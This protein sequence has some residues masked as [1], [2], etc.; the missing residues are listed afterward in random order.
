VINIQ[1][2]NM[3]LFVF[4]VIRDIMNNYQKA[5]VKEILKSV[6][7]E[8]IKCGG[9]MKRIIDLYDETLIGYRCK[10][11]PHYNLLDDNPV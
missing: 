2:R 11:C 7:I 3:A 9:R 1:I 4:I 6:K 5:T 8:C 10:N